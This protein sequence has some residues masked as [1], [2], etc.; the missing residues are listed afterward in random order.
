M[1]RADRYFLHS[2]MC[3]PIAS[4]FVLLAGD[5]LAAQAEVRTVAVHETQE[6]TRV[7]LEIGEPDSAPDYTAFALTS[8]DR[9][10]IDLKNA[11]ISQQAQTF[12]GSAGLVDG[13]RIASRNE[14]DLRVV[15]DLSRSSRAWHYLH[16]A[17]AAGGHRLSVRLRPA[18]VTSVQTG[19][20]EQVPLPGDET[21]LST[22]FPPSHPDAG[23]V[24]VRVAGGAEPRRSTGGRQPLLAQAA[25]ANSRPEQARG[26]RGERNE[27]EE[28][29]FDIDAPPKA[30][31]RLTPTLL[32]GGDIDIEYDFEEN[33]DLNDAEDDDLSVVEP[34]LE[35]ALAY[36]PNEWLEAFFSMSLVREFALREEGRDRDRDTRLNLKQLNVTLREVKKGLSFKLGRQ[37]FEDEREWLYDDELDAVR[38]FYRIGR[39]GLE[40]SISRKNAFNRDLLDEDDDDEE[41]NN[42]FLI[43]RFRPYADADVALFALMRDDTVSNGSSPLFL[44]TQVIGE[45]FDTKY[46]L[47]FAHVRG[48]GDFNPVRASNDDLSAFGLDLGATYEFDNDWKPSVTLAYAFGSGDSDPSDGEDNA[49]RQTGLHDN[50]DR[51][52]GV[53]SFNYYGELFD[54]ELS[55]MK[56]YT[57]GIGVRPSRRSSVDLVYH[58]FRQHKQSDELR[59]AA[60]EED[61]PGNSRSLGDELNLI[62]GFRE[63]KNLSVKLALGYFFPGSAFGPDAAGALLANMKLRYNF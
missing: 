60:V 61:L 27:D 32:W 9:I 59:D 44:G 42:Y 56:V 53:V 45:A 28:V 3:L 19:G 43:G 17:A 30:R 54:P 57:L 14:G 58:H 23:P 33:F 1:R 38:A 41:I 5:A 34:D 24:T 55:N 2:W 13:V 6:D 36:Q 15:L 26:P 39:L 18:A 21:G 62:L 47:S 22:Q 50:S 35:L 29:E 51:F 16:P 11:R 12:R 52:N 8:P 7:T 63:V 48:D 10:V 4:A 31:N 49:F 20:F 46:W 37:R 40:G 25:S